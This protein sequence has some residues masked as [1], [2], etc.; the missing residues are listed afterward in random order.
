MLK[1][2]LTVGIVASG[3][4]TWAKEEVKKDPTGTIRVNRDDLR[5]MMSNYVYSEDNEKLVV[6][7]RDQIIISSLKRGKNVI[8]D[9]TNLNRRNFDDIC[10]LVKSAG[11]DCMVMEKPFYVDLDE[12]KSRNA[13]REGFALIPEDVIEKMWKKSGGTGHKFY[14]GRI[15]MINS[16]NSAADSVEQN[17]DHSLPW[18]IICDLD[19]TV[20][21][22]NVT[23]KD[24]SIEV[25]HPGAPVRNP[26]DASQADND[27]VN[28]PVAEVLEKMAEAG[29]QIIFCS[30]RTEQYRSQTIKFL[31][32]HISFKYQLLMRREDDSRHDEIVKK[33]I[34]DNHIRDKFNVLFVFDDRLKVCKMWHNLGIMLFRVGDPCSD[35]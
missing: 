30:G 25:R 17:I 35:F 1:V 3:K 34:Y 13:K 28:E 11:I 29:Y 9:D 19:G 10:K 8:I 21:L 33:E 7:I 4:S 23:R 16:Y 31:D 26:Y 20:S 18:A 22:F 32:K 14:K 27:M 2:I 12:A 15:E 5:I 24:G 6:S